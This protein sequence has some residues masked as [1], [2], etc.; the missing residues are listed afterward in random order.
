MTPQ[1]KPESFTLW[2]T[3]R[4]F[5]LLVPL[6][7]LAVSLGMTYT[8]WRDA[9]NSALQEL[10]TKLEFR[11]FE[12]AERVRQRMLD[13]DQMLQGLRGLFTASQ[14]VERNEFHE[15]CAALNI[16]ERFPSVQGLA[17]L[18][19]V[20]DTRKNQHIASIRRE[21]FPEYTI[22]PEGKRESYTP[23]IYIEPFSER[24]L[25]A[26]GFDI[27]SEPVRRA[28]L[29]IARDTNNATITK[30]LALIQDG[31]RKAQAGFLMLLPIYQ[32]GTPHDTLDTRRSHI[33]GWVEA[34]FRAEKLMMGVLGNKAEDINVE[35]FDGEE[36]S[37][38]FL[39]YDNDKSLR[40]SSHSGSLLQETQRL[41][42]AGRTW[43]IRVSSLPVFE[44]RLGSNK[45]QLIA[46]GGILVSLLLAF[47]AWILARSRVRS[48]HAAQ[49]L[50]RE[51]NA[52][53]QAEESLRLASMVY[54]YSSEGML[55]TDADN[56]IV[57]INPAFTRIT[58][59]ELQD[60]LGK[61]PSYFS[62]GRY[63]P[64]FYKAMWDELDRT[65]QWQGEIW[66]RRK[67]GELHA[68]YLTINTILNTD[69]SVYRRVALFLD[70]TEKKQSEEFIW[71]QANF[72]ALTQ[73]PNR[74]MFH[75]RLVQEVKKAHRGNLLFALLFIDL[76]LFK[77]VNDTLGHHVGDLLLVEAAKRI[78]ACVR[79]VDT[80]ARLGGDEFTVILSELHD[81]GSV[82]RVSANILE[83]LAAPYTL[84]EE[85][86]HVTGSIGITLYPRDATDPD[87]LLKNADQAMYVAKNRGR[88]RYSYFT[89]ALQEAAHARLRLINDLR[90]AVATHQFSVYYQPIVDLATS[91]IYKAEALIRWQ[92]P[93]R[94]L[95]SPA[96]FIP[97]A[98]ETGLI[99]P[100]GDW[101]FREA[102]RQT[103]RLR[104]I[105]HPAFQISVNKSPKQFRESSNTVTVWFDYLRDLGLSGDSIAIEITEGLLLNA[106]PEVIEKLTS[107]RDGGIQIAIDDFG[108]GYSSLSYL[109]RFHIDYLKID[110][111]FVRDI[112][113]DP[114]DMALS[115]AIIVMAHALGLK[116]IAEGVE[117]SRQ[118]KLLKDAGCDYAQGYFFSEPTPADQFE[119]WLR[120]RRSQP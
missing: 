12:V 78:S 37:E 67:N 66:D 101:V 119:T 108:T 3:G 10:K 93:E 106:V 115:K 114:N 29:E 9:Q 28:A 45:S 13:Y 52:R 31:D 16:A 97:L 88:N 1:S 21:G 61:N 71:H 107:Y 54:E 118:L 25:R 34:V 73:L 48:M 116:V 82:E 40:A 2:G 4:P 41:E 89:P 64:E 27:S 44:R 19:L 81:T 11:T 30:R 42:I 47:M 68:K 17:F 84:G 79:E 102:A 80:V 50:N 15:Y 5:L 33:I 35:I 58:G 77:E 8:L 112:E 60:V 91:E 111:S 98:E 76:D 7:V 94:G 43:T 6:L 85:I 87:G 113:T 96:E 105:H 92:H 24:N 57:A 120:E 110:Q 36:L 53:E 70:I 14:S 90:H 62:S 20:P 99:T 65:G 103:R 39:L 117:T 72:D 86:V 104:A 74:S 95:V 59:Y 46:Q 32:N 83:K 49:A 26:F 75:D 69:G 100:I 18:P 51:L 109:K 56:H 23:V 22:R 55:V 63:D 38:R